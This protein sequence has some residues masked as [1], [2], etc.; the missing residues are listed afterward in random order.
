MVTLYAKNAGLLKIK[1]IILI[2]KTIS[3]NDILYNFL[4]KSLSIKFS[5]EISIKNG[6]I[7]FFDFI[8]D[9]RLSI[10]ISS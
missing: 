6:C 10:N 2:I 7:Q 8:G 4:K 5:N 3:K 9:Y 1:I